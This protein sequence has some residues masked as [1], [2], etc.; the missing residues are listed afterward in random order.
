MSDRFRLLLALCILLAMTGCAASRPSPQTVTMVIESSPN[1]LD[2]R[3]GVDVQSEHI[4]SLIFDSLVHKDAHF[5]LEPWLATSWETPD[6]LTYRFHLRTGVHFHNGQPLTS[7]DVKYTL[8][9]MRNGT[10]ITAKAAAFA[11]VDHIDT[12][13][14]ATVVIH[15]KQPDAALLWNL[16]DGGI[17]IVPLGSGRDFA[18]HPIGSGPFKFAAG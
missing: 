17:G 7:A 6:P 12:P 16:S 9:S 4:G 1:S 5:N 3:I 14:A 13:D 11:H 18:F 2:L 10:V 8:D 15:L